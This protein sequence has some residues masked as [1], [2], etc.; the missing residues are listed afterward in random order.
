MSARRCWRFCR[1]CCDVVFVRTENNFLCTNNT[2][3]HYYLWRRFYWANHGPGHF[4]I[5][6]QWPK[7][8]VQSFIVTYK[9][10]PFGWLAKIFSFDYFSQFCLFI[11]LTDFWGKHKNGLYRSSLFSYSSWF[12]IAFGL[13]NKAKNSMKNE[14]RK[15]KWND[16]DER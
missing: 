7:Y 15:K 11:S 12:H 3:V 4:K 16:F 2:D 8:Y 5:Y 9:T 10:I 6:S 1:H 14:K 13:A